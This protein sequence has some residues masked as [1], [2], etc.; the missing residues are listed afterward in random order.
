MAT[1]GTLSGLAI[2]LE[3]PVKVFLVLTLALRGVGEAQ[4]TLLALRG[5]TGV[6][7]RLDCGFNS[8]IQWLEKVGS[9]RPNIPEDFYT[10]KFRLLR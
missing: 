2:L 9:K 7:E 8:D 4:T 5:E 3:V 1:T 10:R 6:Q